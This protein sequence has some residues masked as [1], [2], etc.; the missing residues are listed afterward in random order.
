M[1]WN[2]TETAEYYI[3]TAE[4]DGGHKVQLTTNDTKTYISEF[5]CGDKYYVSVQSGDS[6]CTSGPSEPFMLLSGT[7]LHTGFII[8]AY[9]A[10][11]GFSLVSHFHH[12]CFTFLP[13][14]RALQPACPAS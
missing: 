4:S 13:Q 3:V 11:T 1:S 14:N 5:M 6:T 8:W 2:A 9:D 10:S 12:F 7:F